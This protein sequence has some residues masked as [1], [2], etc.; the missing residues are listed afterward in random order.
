VGH[1]RQSTGREH[2]GA[3]SLCV[4]LLAASLPSAGGAQAAHAG[5]T[6]PAAR[7]P[8]ASLPN[9]IVSEGGGFA[10]TLATS[11]SPIRLNEP[12]EL[13]VLVRGLAPDGRGPVSVTVDAQM[14]AHK[15]GMSTRPH[16]EQLGEGRFLFRGLLFH[17]AGDWEVVIDA[18]Q[19]RLR[20]RGIVRLVIE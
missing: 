8:A 18:A 7:V 5:H 20:D 16:R 6:E 4:A 13:T 14:P 2:C 12:F 3:L 10:I 17:M 1:I 19:G 11:P 9:S 15:H